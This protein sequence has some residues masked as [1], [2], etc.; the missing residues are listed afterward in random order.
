MLFSHLFMRH[1]TPEPRFAPGLFV[2]LVALFGSMGQTRPVVA[3][4]GVG[5]VLLL[6]GVLVELNRV[7]IWEGYLKTYK[8]KRGIKSFWTKPSHMYYTINVLFLWPFIMFIG[9]VC[10]WA[11][12]SLA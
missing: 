6:S 4:A 9:L 8:K 2:A 7:R 5:T 12:Y 1:K 11:A 3:L 10:I